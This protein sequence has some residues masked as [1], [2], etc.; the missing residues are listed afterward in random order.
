MRKSEY[1]SISK[2]SGSSDGST[3]SDYVNALNWICDILTRKHILLKNTH[4]TNDLKYKVLV[5][6]FVDGIEY[7]E[8][9]ETTLS[10]GDT[11]K[12]VLNYSYSQVLIPVKDATS[13]TVATYTIDWTGIKG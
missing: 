12:I 9:V 6:A 4:A 13:G 1:I 2:D 11:A 7:T 5:Y 10:A 3:T 8:V